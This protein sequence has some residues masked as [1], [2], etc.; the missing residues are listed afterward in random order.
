MLIAGY[1]QMSLI[2]SFP[3]QIGH[4]IVICHL[5]GVFDIGSRGPR[6]SVV[7]AMGGTSS[8]YLRIR[9]RPFPGY[10]CF[11]YFSVFVP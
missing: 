7:S 2:L 1:G 6:T 4:R 11:R 3:I 10:C 9:F 5:D 8:S